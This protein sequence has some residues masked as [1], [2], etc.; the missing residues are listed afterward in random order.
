MF[1]KLLI[2]NRGEIASRIIR[3]CKRLN[4]QTVAIYSEPDEDSPYVKEADEAYP[5]GGSRVHESYLQVDKVL[6]IAKNA[7]VDAIHPG[8]GLLSENADFAERI[9]SEG[10]TFVGPTSDVIRSMGSKVEART[11]MKRAGVPIIPGTSSSTEDVDAAIE[12]ASD[13]GYPIMLKASAGGGGIGMQVVNTDEEL[14]K[15]Y[16]S[17]AKRAQMFFGDGTMFLEKKIVNPH[18]IEIQVLADQEG[19]ALYLFERECSVQRRHQK[20]VEEAPSPFI[21]EETREKMG[22]AALKAV[23][24]LGYQNAGTVEFLVDENQQ[25]YFLEMNT[26]LQVE[27]PVTEEITGFDL[28]EEQIRIAYGESLR[29]KQNELTIHGHA[30]EVRVYAEDPKTFYPAPGQMTDLQIPVGD[31]IRHE[32]AVHS[33]SFVSPFYD[34][35]IAKCITWGETR[36]EAIER[37]SYALSQYEVEGIKTNLPMLRTVLSH[38]LFKQGNIT[39]NFVE[40]HYLKEEAK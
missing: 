30:I 13:I 17:N 37:M 25:F 33:S 12:A 36:E 7:N 10:I 22:G 11:T 1:A 6:D 35:M 21:S 19:N 26:R 29:Y 14:R 5:L 9:Q 3:T 2:A 8:Y 18:H 16:G 15:A 39:T 38:D 24:A 4:I 23:R 34:P 28:V 40:E 20:V 31:H 27:H 32:L